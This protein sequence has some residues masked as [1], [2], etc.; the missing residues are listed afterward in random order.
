MFPG[1]LG[2]MEGTE[3]RPKI[4]VQNTLL[5][6]LTTR[7]SHIEEGNKPHHSPVQKEKICKGNN[8]VFLCCVLIKI[9]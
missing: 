6:L 3:A 5:F 7:A 2:V 8:G 1:F 4:P 9:R